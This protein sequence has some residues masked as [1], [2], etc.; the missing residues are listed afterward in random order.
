[1]LSSLAL[2]V[3]AIL[4]QNCTQ[5]YTH[6]EWRE[7][8]PAQQTGYVEAVK[9]MNR[10]APIARDVAGSP[11][12]RRVQSL[13]QE[14]VD[15]HRMAGS[16]FHNS[17]R[18][19]S[20]HRLFLATVDDLMR[21]Q[22]NYDG[23]MP[24]WD[25][26]IDSQAPERSPVWN[27]THGL[28][29]NGDGQRSCVSGPFG[30]NFTDMNG[31]CLTRTWANQAQNGGSLLPAFYTPETI[32]LI[33]DEPTFERMARRLEGVPHNNV[34]NAIGGHMRSPALAN[35]DPVFYLHHR[36]VDRIWYEWQKI[37]PE[38]ALDH[39][40]QTEG[41][42][43]MWGLLT[44]SGSVNFVRH[45]NESYQV[46]DVLSTN[47]GAAKGL[48]CYEYSSSV[49]P[50]APSPAPSQ[51]LTRRAVVA[52][53]SPDSFDRS[54][55]KHLHKVLP[56]SDDFFATWKYSEADVAIIRA[57]EA[58]A[59]A[60]ISRLNADETYQ[61]PVRLEAVEAAQTQGWTKTNNIFKILPAMNAFKG[62][63]RN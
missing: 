26:T 61:S 14:L 40:R 25:W 20:W 39:A 15:L 21:K 36:N 31:G 2:L 43:F 18:F 46:K 33:L 53:V 6:R 45:A 17:L 32:K 52:S 10:A 13:W 8:S 16:D 9:C 12:S 41:D 47:S 48:M 49:L 4:A 56:I 59:R 50:P 54:D 58:E 11:I 24:Y 22:C 7:L 19:L 38:R 55:K 1:M 57:Q 27:M 35:F 51:N 29:G 44:K 5:T 30:T 42:L 37:S 3:A 28:G 63:V 60:L 34:H 23:P 62:I